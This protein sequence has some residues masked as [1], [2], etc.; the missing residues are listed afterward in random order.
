MS[1]IDFEIG[2]GNEGAAAI[3]FHGAQHDYLTHMD[4]H[5]GSAFAGVHQVG[6]EART[7]ASSAAA[8]AS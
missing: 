1:N 7:C 4:F 3:R 8:T 2:K 5:L 6:N